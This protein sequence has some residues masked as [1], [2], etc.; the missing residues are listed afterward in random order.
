M[1][2]RHTNL[3]KR[4]RAAGVKRGE[5]LDMQGNVLHVGDYIV[6]LHWHR[7]AFPLMVGRVIEIDGAAYHAIGVYEDKN[8]L[9][10]VTNERASSEHST[11]L[12]IDLQD[13]R[14]KDIISA[15]EAGEL[16]GRCWRRHPGNLEELVIQGAEYNADISA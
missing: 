2:R 14:I 15:V 6:T 16:K 3:I 13:G 11:F 1:I 7:R 12:I 9:V 10:F 4:W 8:G 5:L